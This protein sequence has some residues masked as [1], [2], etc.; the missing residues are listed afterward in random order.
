VSETPPPRS[1][2]EPQD[3]APPSFGAQRL[4]GTIIDKYDILEKVGEG[5]MATVY[6]ARHRTLSRD[7]AV[8]LMHPMLASTRGHRQRFHREAHTWESLRHPNIPRILDFSGIDEDQCYIVSEFVDG[9]NLADLLL[10]LGTVPSEFAAM[11]GIEVCRALQC[12]HAQQIVHRDVKPENVMVTTGGRVLLMDFGIARLLD[13]ASMTLT[14]SLVGSPAYMSPEQAAEAQVDHRSDLFSLGTVLFHAAA[15][16]LPFVGQNTIVVLRHILEGTRP[17]LRELCPEANP[18]VAATVESLLSTEPDGRPTSATETLEDLEGALRDVGLDPASPPD[19]PLSLS[20]F[21]GDP[22]AATAALNEHLVRRLTEDGRTALAEGRK[23]RALAS[24]DRV[25]CLDESNTEVVELLQQ[26]VQ[27]GESYGR[28]RVLWAALSLLLAVAVAGG[29]ALWAPTGSDGAEA[30]RTDIEP[31][32]GT[33]PA[34]PELVP[35]APEPLSPPEQEGPEPPRP[36]PAAPPSRAQGRVADRPVVTNPSS[37]V[38]VVEPTPDEP[39]SGEPATLQ[40]TSTLPLDLW[41]DGEN[42]APMY[43]GHAR[44]SHTLAIG[45]RRVCAHHRNGSARPFCKTYTVRGGETLQ[46]TVVQGDLDWKPLTLIIDAS[47]PP[48]T[49]VTVDGEYKGQTP[50]A[51]PIRVDGLAEHRVVLQAPGEMARSYTVLPRDAGPGKTHSVP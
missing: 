4:E 24:F 30:V 26:A 2:G 1:T 3:A 47:V 16:R 31:R 5:G 23:A 46:H 14:G 41:V 12:A 34:A 28:R 51:A 32:D 42:I 19:H 40:W 18:L 11:I 9:D 35:V 43:G 48:G 37:A 45:T 22:E 38:E 7:V 8:K 17:A 25:L 36:E 50:L 13:A 39:A 6:R 20:A 27:A 10:R 33:G 44:E 29:V 49:R 21:I 15:G